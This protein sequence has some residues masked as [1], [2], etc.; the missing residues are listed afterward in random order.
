MRAMISRGPDRCNVMP[1][2]IG[3][4]MSI[5]SRRDRITG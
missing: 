5:A 2:N 1:S 3:M 4:T